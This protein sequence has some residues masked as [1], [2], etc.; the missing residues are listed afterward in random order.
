MYPN[1]IP[2]LDNCKKHLPEFAGVLQCKLDCQF[3]CTDL[4]SIEKEPYQN[5]CLIYERLKFN[6]KTN[7]KYTWSYLYELI[8]YK[9]IKQL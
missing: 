5:V 3:T 8:F 1:V 4:K 6:S 9:W 7:S 2:A